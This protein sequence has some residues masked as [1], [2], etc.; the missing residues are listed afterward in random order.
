MR[1]VFDR[2]A[3]WRMTAHAHFVVETSLLYSGFVRVVARCARESR[4]AISPATA[5]RQTGGRKPQHKYPTYWIE[6]DIGR[7]AVAGA[8]E[9]HG[10][11]RAKAR[12]IENKCGTPRIMLQ[13]HL[14]D[15]LC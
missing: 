14:R 7:C 5:L 3:R 4:I 10:V 9:I 15:M 11:I 1:F 12:G 8:T 13:A 6:R 2:G